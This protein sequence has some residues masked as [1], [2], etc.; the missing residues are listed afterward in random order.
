MNKEV[1]MNPDKVRILMLLV[2]SIY[3][4]MMHDPAWVRKQSDSQPGFLFDKPGC[5]I[6]KGDLVT[7]MTSIW[8]NDFMVGFVEEVIGPDALLIREIGSDR[9]CE[10]SNER[11]IRIDKDLLGYEILEGKEY[12]VYQKCLKAFQE[13]YVY[14]FG[15]IQFDKN[16]VTLSARKVFSEDIAFTIEFYYNSKTS[17]KSI[18][19]KLQEQIDI[20]SARK[21]DTQNDG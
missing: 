21:D 17:I 18:R 9:T 16:K 19:D 5:E 7:A 2:N 4:K 11:F 8:Y 13:Y 10:Y 14:R 12:E 3:P 20:C 1:S 6:K 15:G